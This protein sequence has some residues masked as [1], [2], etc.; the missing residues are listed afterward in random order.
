MEEDLLQEARLK[1]IT[2]IAEK[3]DLQQNKVRFSTYAFQC[4]SRMVR[5][6]VRKELREEVSLDKP[7]GEEGETMLD[8]IPIDI[9]SISAR[10]CT[11]KRGR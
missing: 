11:A 7:V 3:F 4:L 2:E 8:F 10:D 1:I 6:I 5:D 9:N